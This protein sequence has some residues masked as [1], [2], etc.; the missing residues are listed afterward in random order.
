MILVMNKKH[1]VG[2]TTLTYN[3]GRLLEIP[4]F[5]KEDSFMFDEEHRIFFEDVGKITT[6]KRE[7]IFDIGAEYNKAFVKRFIE[8]DAKVAVVPLDFGYETIV[9][10]IETIKYIQNINSD[11]PVVLILNRL[12]KQDSDKDFNYK[13]YLKLKFEDAGIDFRRSNLVLTYLRNSYGLYNDFDIG[14]YFMDNFFSD[15][16]LLEKDRDRE[17]LSKRIEFFEYKQFLVFTNEALAKTDYTNEDI[18]IQDK[19]MVEFRNNFKEKYPDYEEKYD[20]FL[21]RDNQKYTHSYSDI[22]K[23]CNKYRD[24]TPLYQENKLIKDMAFISH[25]VFECFASEDNIIRRRMYRHF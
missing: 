11:L 17:D 14:N 12:D 15:K 19:D 8:S 20:Y 24:K 16:H 13:E 23:Y 21:R 6:S 18:Y 1:G 10:T 3:L 25:V 7:G 4:I 22:T 9:D 5:V 2:C